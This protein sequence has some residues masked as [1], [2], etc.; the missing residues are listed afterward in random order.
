VIE[1]HSLEPDELPTALPALSAILVDC[2]RGGAS[3]EFM[4]TVTTDDANSYWR[5]AFDRVMSGR[6]TLL[7]ATHDGAIVGTVSLVRVRQQN[8]QHRAEISKLLVDPHS[9]RRG[10]ADMLMDAVEAEAWRQGLTMLLL[11]T[12]TGSDASRVY[13]RRGW[14]RAGDIPN[15][16]LSP[17]GEMCSTSFY[18]LAREASASA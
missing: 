6:Q 2:V 8:Q 4:A 14:A 12:V 18:W 16:A 13:E 3:V 11:D 7:V 15:Y 10:I 9:R 17:A 1:I 5:S